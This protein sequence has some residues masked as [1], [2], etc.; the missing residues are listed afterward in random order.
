MSALSHGIYTIVHTASGK[1]YV[2]SSANLHK[3]IA[4]H[5][6]LLKKGTHINRKLQNAF[7]KYGECSFSFTPIIYCAEVDLIFYE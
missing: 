6:R 2:G 4:E 3:R 5:K 1:H 7:A